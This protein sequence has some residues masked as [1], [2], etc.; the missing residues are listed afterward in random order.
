LKWSK[1]LIEEKA[2]TN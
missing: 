2:S 1:M